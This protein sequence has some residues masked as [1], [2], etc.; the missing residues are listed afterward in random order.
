[1]S[2]LTITDETADLAAEALRGYAIAESDL[3]D[4]GSE[5]LQAAGP[6]LLLNAVKARAAH[7]RTA[8]AAAKTS[9]E[10][11]EAIRQA[12]AMEAWAD[13]LSA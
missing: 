11:N 1:M 9:P 6:A 2:D 13:E 12:A 5:V 10:L 8:A 4:A 3:I 7:L